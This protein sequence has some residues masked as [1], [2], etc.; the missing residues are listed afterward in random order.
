[1][2]QNPPSPG[3]QNCGANIPVTTGTTD[4][5]Q[6]A[7]D[8]RPATPGGSISAS[9]IGND[10]ILCGNVA[11]TFY[12]VTPMKDS[13]HPLRDGVTYVICSASSTLTTCR[14]QASLGTFNLVTANPMT[15]N[16]PFANADHLRRP[17]KPRNVQSGHSKPDDAEST[18]AGTNGGLRRAD[19]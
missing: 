16:P 1:M 19:E 6:D 14:N 3:L 12:L 9:V 18:V 8:L 2:T 7:F 5:I 11:S 10:Q 17:D 4:I 13:T 15:Q